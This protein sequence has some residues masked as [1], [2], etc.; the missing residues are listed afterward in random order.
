MKRSTIYKPLTFSL[1]LILGIYLGSALSFRPGAPG[2]L[3]NNLKHEKLK[4]LIRYIDYE[5]VDVVN[6]DSLIDL[7][8]T[9]LLQNLDP[10]STYIPYAQVQAVEEQ[11]RGSFDGIGVSFSVERDTVL[12]VEALEDGPSKALGIQPGDRIIAVDGDTIAGVGITSEGVIDHLKGA[13]G[14]EVQ[15][16]ILRPGIPE[17]LDFTITRE[18]IPIKSVDVSYMIQPEVGYI[19]LNR[20]AETSYDE[21]IDAFEALRAKGMQ[22]L[23]LDL[24]GNPGGFLHIATQL[25]DE[26]L[27]DKQLIV[28]TKSRSEK[29]R[30]TYATKKGA[31][32]K[33]ELL[34]LIDENSASASEIVAGAVQ[35]NDRALVVGRRSFGKGLVQE[36]MGLSDGSRVRLTISRYYTPTGRSIQKSYD[37]G[38]DAYQSE[39]ASRYENGELLD[40]SK[41]QIQDSLAFKT[42]GGK[43]VYGGG[44]ISPDVF[45]PID[46][47]GNTPWYRRMLNRSAI[48]ISAFRYATTHEEELK[49]QNIDSFMSSFEVPDDLLEDFSDSLY[50]MARDDALETLLKSQLKAMIAKNIWGTEAFYKSLFST[51]TVLKKSLELLNP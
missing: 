22:K 15:I 20:F 47:L 44:G 13:K 40:S 24:R 35:D 28:Y 51:D 17:L 33:G 29:P 6:T 32:E 8:I 48:A 27:E 42:P 38:Y 14:S 30:Y 23:I 25:A 34:V 19:K 36:E 3:E 41:V 26:F 11:M 21:Y 45:V 50:Y 43:I 10:H 31:F 4:Q 5:Y 9:K 1:V 12:V 39:A 7:T 46:T 2:F 49:K 16:A 37:E 18:R